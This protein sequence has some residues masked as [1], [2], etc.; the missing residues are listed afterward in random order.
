MNRIFKIFIFVMFV[1]TSFYGQSVLN[2]NIHQ[3]WRTMGE[4][5][6]GPGGVLSRDKLGLMQAEELQLGSEFSFGPH[7]FIGPKVTYNFSTLFFSCGGSVIY[8]S[9]F[10]NYTVCLHPHLG[11]SVNTFADLYL[12]YNIPVGPNK[13]KGYINRFTA[14]LAIPLMKERVIKEKKKKEETKQTAPDKFT[15]HAHPTL[16]TCILAPQTIKTRKNHFFCPNV[17]RNRKIT[18]FASRIIKKQ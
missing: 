17:G 12:G 15:G 18:I 6:F 3:G 2:L 1:H 9:D 16:I 4:I 8:Y 14:T 7:F 13:M 10:K 11:L 5:A